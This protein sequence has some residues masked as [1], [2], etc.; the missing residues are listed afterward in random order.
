[1]KCRLGQVTTVAGQVVHCL[2]IWESLQ[3]RLGAQSQLLCFSLFYFGDYP[4]AR[5]SARQSKTLAHT[6][7][8]PGAAYGF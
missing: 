7:S 3:V 6:L 8:G 5:I 2:V 4:L 1:M